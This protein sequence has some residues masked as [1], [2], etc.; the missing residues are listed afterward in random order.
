MHF[1][2]PQY[3]LI[4]QRKGGLYRPPFLRSGDIPSSKRKRNALHTTVYITLRL[5]HRGV[6]L[7][8]QKVA[9]S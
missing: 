3:R 9:A 2:N 7:Y 1:P 4:K 6:L 8:L 5:H